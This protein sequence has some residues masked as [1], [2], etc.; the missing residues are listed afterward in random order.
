MKKN[1]LRSKKI[2]FLKIIETY[3]LCRISLIKE[4]NQT[5][6][7][8][9]FK[10]MKCDQIIK[11]FET[12]EEYLCSDEYKIYQIILLKNKRNQWWKEYY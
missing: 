2:K 3:K 12:I 10:N 5:I 4:N 6:N 8:E 11:I 7:N 9:Y 1:N